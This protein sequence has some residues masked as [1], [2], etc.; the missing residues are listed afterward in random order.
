L[1]L[2]YVAPYDFRALLGFLEARAIPG[3]ESVR[4]GCY[5]RT[6]ASGSAHGTLRVE[7]DRP[8]RLKLT[9]QLPAVTELPG[10]LARV[11][12]LFDLASDP[13]AIGAHLAEDPALGP[14][15]ARRPGLRVPGAWDGFELAVRAVLGQQITVTAATR[16]AGRL[17]DLCGE[18]AVTADPAL[19]RVFP[20]PSAVARA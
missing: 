14:L 13:I 6:I 10:V 8:G 15:V 1:A 4:D 18:R 16:L 17:A 9:V 5:A 3:V 20:T 7:E 19:S 2:P 11:R 12:R